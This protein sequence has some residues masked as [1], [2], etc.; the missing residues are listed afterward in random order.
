[1]LPTIFWKEEPKERKWKV[2]P[3]TPE[4]KAQAIKQGAMFF[5]WTAV[6][7]AFKGNGQPEPHR[8]GD[9]PLDFD[10]KDDPEKAL[11]DLR[12]LCL[13]HLPEFFGV[14]PY[15]IEYYA[16]GSKGF[17][18]VIPA[19]F[20]DAADG[21]RYLPLSYKRI[22]AEWKQ[23]LELQTLDLSLYNMQRGKMFRIPNIQRS[24]GR[25]KV[26]L[27]L[28]EV[29]DLPIN[30]LTD[31][32]KAPRE[33]DPVETD[34]SESEEL[35]NLYRNAKERVHGELAERPEPELSDQERKRLSKSLPAC[36]SYILTAMPAKSEKVNFN[37]L[38][39][40]LVTYFQMTGWGKGDVWARVESFI[41][42]YS[43]SDTYDTPEKRIA[44][45][46]SEWKYL[47]N[48]PSYSF[49]CGYVKGLGLPGTAFDCKD[50]IG[51]PKQKTHDDVI[52]RA[53]DF[54]KIDLPKTRVFLNPWLQ[55]QSITLISGWRGVGKSWFAIDLLRSVSKGEPFGPWE[56]GEP[57]PA[58]YLDGEMIPQD[59]IKR[60]NQ[61]DSDLP[62]NIELYIYSDALANTYGLSRVNLLSEKWRSVMG[63]IL[64]TRG[65]KLWVLDNIVSTTPGIDENSQ[66]EWSPIND[67][68]LNLRFQGISTIL[69]HHTGKG[70]AQRGTSGREDNI[71]TSIELKRPHDYTA[72]DG[73]RFICH[74]TK[75]RVS[76]SDLAATADIE[77]RLTP[78]TND[79]RLSWTWGNVKRE[80]KREILRMLDEGQDYN[81]IKD[82][83]GVSKAYISKIKN[84]AVKDKL[85]SQEG[86]LS[87]LGYEFLRGKSTQRPVQDVVQ[88][89]VNGIG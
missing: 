43:Y 62:E 19:K 74:F 67:W 5:T 36:I 61:L 32:T 46:K 42:N 34:I 14:D 12:A 17:H 20:F 84:T 66:R 70:G 1:M 50:C 7:D 88:E 80:R 16:S 89:L 25:Y 11:Q 2:I 41:T 54:I 3:N 87:Y 35:G 37:K 59:V 58:L 24:N 77:F 63:R 38:V 27:T 53:S 29:R 13:V 49:N 48:N 18:S 85:I 78:N 15:A 69:L 6:S 56:A 10:S 83:L 44:H 28:E 30:E 57:V 21:D 65:I 33:I 9:F 26:P 51:E 40:L 68:L 64:L 79:D 60:L 75:A 72:E 73:A 82:D 86:K 52:L 55:E 8:W 45:F 47:S 39:M 22:A 4:A 81:S 31:L 23:K 76:T 71:N